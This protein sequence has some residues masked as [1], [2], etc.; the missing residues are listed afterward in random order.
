MP[1][2]QSPRLSGLLF[3]DLTSL[4]KLAT[5]KHPANC[6]KLPGRCLFPLTLVKTAYQETNIL[7]TEADQAVQ[8]TYPLCAQR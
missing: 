4:G 5:F 3:L 7:T 2:P 6:L 1:P 8:P